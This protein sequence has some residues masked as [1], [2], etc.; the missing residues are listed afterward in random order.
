MLNADLKKF[1]I[2]NFNGFSGYNEELY[3]QLCMLIRDNF[4]LRFYLHKI[5]N[6]RI[7][8]TPS[9]VI[10]DENGIIILDANRIYDNC[11]KL[12]SKGSFRKFSSDLKSSLMLK[13]ILQMVRYI[14]D[15][16]HMDNGIERDKSPIWHG[17]MARLGNFDLDLYAKSIIDKNTVDRIFYLNSEIYPNERRA[18]IQSLE[19]VIEV[20]KDCPNMDE[21]L[22]TDLLIMLLEDK[23]GA[24]SLS[25]GSLEC[26]VHKF[27]KLVGHPE[28]YTE[29]FYSYYSLSER[30]EMGLPISEE[31]LVDT[32]IKTLE[33]NPNNEKA[34]R[35]ART[36]IK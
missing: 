28:F 15:F 13:S 34:L 26:P 32:I 10:Y 20:Y 5:V 23:V 35:F 22:L 3:N 4:D 2:E 9:M 19:S 27:Y 12:I 14:V 6:K 33:L 1:M 36:Y 16:N 11:V 18:R 25:K 24:Y 29:R 7:D 31:E 21:E 30:L 8:R 17:Y